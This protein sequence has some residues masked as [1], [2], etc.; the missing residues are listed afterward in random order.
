MQQDPADT[1]AKR[2]PPQKK[3]KVI[4][5]YMAT[6]ADL[7]MIL[8]CFFILLLSMAEIDVIRYKMVAKTMANAFGVSQTVEPDP[9]PAGTS[10][11]KQTFSP[12][13]TDTLLEVD[14][15]QQADPLS[16][17]LSAKD[18]ELFLQAQLEDLAAQLELSLQEAIQSGQL[19]L[20]T[21]EDRVVLVLDDRSSFDS[22]RADI[23]PDF[24]PVISE[25]AHALSKK[26]QPLVVAGHTDNVPLSSASYRSNWELSAARATSVVHTLLDLSDIKEERF[27]IEGYAET[28]PVS[29]NQTDA[30]RSRNRRVEIAVLIQ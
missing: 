10:V 20:E 26:E 15:T 24:I 16:R 6:F 2:Q 11:I 21:R 18:V 7:M 27:R 13:P 17:P 14:I 29:T 3:S 28:R 19:Q 30:G 4:P 8:L 9:I 12:N 25:I 1:E 5:S 22:G 23:K